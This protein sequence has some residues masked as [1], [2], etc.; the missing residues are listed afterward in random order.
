MTGLRLARIFM[1]NCRITYGM[2]KVTVLV[3]HYFERDRKDKI[4]KQI[5]NIFVAAWV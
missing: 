1:R 3:S 4:G 2:M 5:N